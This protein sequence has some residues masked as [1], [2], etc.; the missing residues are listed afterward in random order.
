MVFE[1]EVFIERVLDV[2]PN[3]QKYIDS[4][5]DTINRMPINK[6]VIEQTKDFISG[7]VIEG[8]EINKI[9]NLISQ[10]LDSIKINKKWLLDEI[11]NFF[12][13]D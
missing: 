3:I 6:S 7:L 5:R 2:E 1:R 8:V 10:N 9:K 13:K 11:D 12:Y 4:F